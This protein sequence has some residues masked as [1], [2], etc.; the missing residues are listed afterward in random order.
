MNSRWID[1]CQ[2]LRGAAFDELV[3]DEES[4]EQRNILPIGCGKTVV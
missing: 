2:F 3:V 4:S 1:T